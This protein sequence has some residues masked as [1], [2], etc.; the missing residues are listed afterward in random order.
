MQAETHQILGLSD[1]AANPI[2]QRDRYPRS[3][4]VCDACYGGSRDDYRL[5]TCGDESS[6]SLTD[7]PILCTFTQIISRA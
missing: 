7:E 3:K 2:H 5:G 1:S 4:P 6:G